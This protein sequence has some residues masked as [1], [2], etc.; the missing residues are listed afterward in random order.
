MMAKM[1]W[2]MALAMIMCGTIHAADEPKPQ[3]PVAGLAVGE[4]LPGSMPPES[5]SFSNV[6]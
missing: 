2:L 5:G 1:R 3:A 6:P 4:L